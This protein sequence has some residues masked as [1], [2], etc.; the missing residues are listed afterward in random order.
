[1]TSFTLKTIY[2]ENQ[3]GPKLEVTLSTQFIKE[4]TCKWLLE[5]LKS[6]LKQICSSEKLPE[7]DRIV[8]LQTTDAQYAVDQWLTLPHKSANILENGTILKPFYKQS[9]NTK[10][11]STKIS[12]DDFIIETKLG[13]GAFSNVYLGNLLLECQYENFVQ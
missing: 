13:Y 7:I 11:N 3:Y 10:K 8:A 9:S 12:L 1:M 4:Q 2:I 6:K 5:E